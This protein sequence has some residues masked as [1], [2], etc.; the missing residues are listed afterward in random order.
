MKTAAMMNAI[1]MDATEM[2]E[3]AKIN[4]ARC[5]GCGLCVSVCPYSAPSFNEDG[6]FLAEL[7]RQVPRD[8]EKMLTPADYEDLDRIGRPDKRL[9]NVIMQ[10]AA[11][12]QLGRVGDLVFSQ[13]GRFFDIYDIHGNLLAANKN[14]GLMQMTYSYEDRIVMVLHAGVDLEQ[15][16][17]PEIRQALVDLDYRY[18]DNPYLL[19]FRLKELTGDPLEGA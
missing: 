6:R 2:D 7:G 19:I 15:V 16:D 13:M 1:E 12:T 14:G 17:R 8:P 11:N 3:T 5:I 4:S 18:D 10:K 9:R